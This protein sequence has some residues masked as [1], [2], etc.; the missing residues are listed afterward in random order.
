MNESMTGSKLLAMGMAKRG[1]NMADAAKIIG[2]DQSTIY[3]WV[4]GETSPTPRMMLALKRVYGIPIEA[5]VDDEVSPT[6]TD[7]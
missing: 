2:C 3:R 7:G 6:G 4:V 5:W 1:H